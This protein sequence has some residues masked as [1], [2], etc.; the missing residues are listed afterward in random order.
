MKRN[1]TINPVIWKTLTVKQKF[2]AVVGRILYSVGYLK[3]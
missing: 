2:W 3:D 1:A